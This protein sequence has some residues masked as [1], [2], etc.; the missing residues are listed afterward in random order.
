M[1]IAIF[2]DIHGNEQALKAI[3][4]DIKN[5]NIDKTYCLG[6]VIAIGPNSRECLDII[7]E[8]NIKMVLGNHEL[9]YLKGTQIDY[10]M[11]EGEK[12]HQRWVREQL[13]DKHKDFL[14]SCQLKIEEK[15]ANKK[16]CY[17][18]F[19][20]N[21]DKDD[22]YP[23]DDFK[24]VH[25]GSINNKVNLLNFDITFIGHEHK[26]FEIDNGNKKLIDVGS[27]GCS[28]NENTCYTI[29]TFEDNK[30]DIKKK[31]IVYNRKEFEN[32]FKIINYPEK[33]IINKIF[34]GVNL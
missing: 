14:N 29:L 21:E 32:I 3:L 17:Q 19:L 12:A 28:K 33:E 8:N 34:F 4:D 2:S 18:H 5:N 24:I 6:D 31:N 7:I 26:A 11:G 30:F 9:Y 25:D 16:I 15:I 27:S 10:E 20:L 1:R 22:I 13:D 23:F